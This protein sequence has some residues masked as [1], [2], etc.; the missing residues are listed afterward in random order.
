M[1]PDEIEAV[2]WEKYQLNLL[3][4]WALAFNRYRSDLLAEDE[5]AAW[6]TYFTHLFSH[7]GEKISD[8]RWRELEYGFGPAFWRHVDAALFGRVRP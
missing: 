8:Q 1:V 4:I 2:R 6:D 5:R 7:G 3:D